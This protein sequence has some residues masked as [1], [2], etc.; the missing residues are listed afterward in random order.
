[1]ENGAAAVIATIYVLG[2]VNEAI[3]QYFNREPDRPIEY[4]SWLVSAVIWP[5][6]ACLRIG[7]LVWERVGILVWERVRRVY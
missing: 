2:V 1:V 6:S 4:A 3:W 5:A 7:I